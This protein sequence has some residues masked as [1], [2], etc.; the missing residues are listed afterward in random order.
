[1]SLKNRSGFVLT[2]LGLGLACL[3]C[4]IAGCR[5][6]AVPDPAETQ[7]EAFP[8][9]VYAAGAHILIAHDQSDPPVPGVTRSRREARNLASSLFMEACNYPAG[10]NE[11]ARKYSDD[12]YVQSTGG[13][14]GIHTRRDLP[15]PI[16]VA[17][18]ETGFR[19]IHSPVETEQGF[20]I[21]MRLPI[22]R[23]PTRHILISWAGAAR[24]DAS[25]KRSRE[26]ARIIAEE[27]HS[28]CLLEDA[29]FCE[30]AARYSDDVNSRFA[31]GEIGSIEPGMVPPAFEFVLFRLQ[32]GE[33]SEIVETEFGFHIITLAE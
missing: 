1:M 17:L 13:Y 21:V 16:S 6:D 28:L 14:F 24:A 33:I 26:Q 9:S 29:D 15:L 12:P 27:I 11:L 31:C 23:I 7:N 8:D 19:Q 25:V 32:P 3:A 10:F 18:F 20:H 30:L 5:D 22:V 2:M 4:M